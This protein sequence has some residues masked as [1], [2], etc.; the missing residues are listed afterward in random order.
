MQVRAGY[1]GRRE[2]HNEKREARSQGQ[3]HRLWNGNVQ[4]IAEKVEQI[5]ID[6]DLRA[7]VI[8]AQFFCQDLYFQVNLKEAYQTKFSNYENRGTY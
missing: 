8:G 3:M 5:K 6:H 4:D 1:Q 7:P 2:S